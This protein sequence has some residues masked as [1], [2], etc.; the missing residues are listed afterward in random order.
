MDAVV[1]A[2]R[3]GTESAVGGPPTLA[4]PLLDLFEVSMTRRAQIVEMRNTSIA[5]YAFAI[6]TVQA[7]DR[8]RECS[9]GGVVEIGAGTGYWAHALHQR[10]VDVEAYDIEPAPSLRNAWFAGTPPWYRVQR[11]DD[12]VAG[13]HPGRTLLIVW[14]TKN[15]IWAAAAVE[16][17]FEAG[18]M[19]VVHVGEGPGGRTG[20]DVFHAL[21]GELVTCAQC[22]YGSTTSP[23][24]CDVTA[25]WCRTETI[26]LPHWTGYHDD[27]HVY[28][29]RPVT[30]DA[31]ASIPETTPTLVP[32][33]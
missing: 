32:T 14:P 26:V 28:S 19:C 9:P 29:P 27:V 30:P 24:I 13:E 12:G 2:L 17:Y 7:L 31:A 15:E 23:C 21:L 5:K 22:A 20:D 4:N 33:E 3:T 11:R 6:P 16:R 1:V 10:G 25:Q 18:G 8:I